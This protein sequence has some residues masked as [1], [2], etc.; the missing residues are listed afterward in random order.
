[1]SN[2]YLIIAAS[3]GAAVSAPALATAAP[4]APA[5][6]AQAPKPVTR[7]QFSANIQSRFSAADTNHDGNL[8]ASEVGAAQQ[9]E[10][11][12]ARAGEQQKAEAEFAK[13]D[14][15]HDGQLS[16]AEFLA[17][18]PNVQP[19]QTAQQVIGAIDSKQGRQDQPRGI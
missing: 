15:N 10:V 16:K 18:V 2:R 12:Q 6:A 4:A 1:M 8:D 13:L 19:R 11:Q 3:I 5:P 9:K 17:I 14:T 7:T